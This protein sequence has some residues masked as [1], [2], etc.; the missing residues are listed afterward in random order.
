MRDEHTRDEWRRVLRYPALALDAGRCVA[1]EA[2]YDARLAAFDTSAG[3]SPDPPLPRCADPD[4]QPFLELA[5]A[6]G[7]CALLTRDGELLRLARRIARQGRFAIL[8]PA[9][10]AVQGLPE[11]CGT[12]RL[13]PAS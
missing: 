12:R 6:S 5:F 3:P 10:F 8:S 13:A 7:A 1:L 11:A 2:E 9:A 4:D